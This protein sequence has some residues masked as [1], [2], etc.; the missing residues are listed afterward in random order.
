MQFKTDNTIY[1][2]DYGNTKTM[3]EAVGRGVD[4]IEKA[5][6]TLV[7]AERVSI[8]EVTSSDALVVGTPVHMCSCDWRVKKC[9]DTICSRLWMKD[10]LVGKVSGVFA[11]GGGYGGGAG[12]AELAMLS[13]INLSSTLKPLFFRIF[14]PKSPI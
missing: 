4:S 6:S 2:S 8:E 12:G 7:E 14:C 13:I 11:S 1:A 3:A 5:S 9:I 10:A